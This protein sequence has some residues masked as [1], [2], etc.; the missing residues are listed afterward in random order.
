MCNGDCYFDALL[1]FVLFRQLGLQ[2][3]GESMETD[4]T[5]KR[6]ICAMI[7]KIEALQPFLFL[8]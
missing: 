2:L 6:Y 3:A 8:C 1:Q 4:T 5:E 7:R